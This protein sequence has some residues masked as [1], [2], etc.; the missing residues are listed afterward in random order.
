M[1]GAGEHEEVTLYRPA[2]CGRCNHTGYEGR[3]GVYELIV[4]DDKLKRLIHDGAS[5]QDIAAYAVA[6]ADTLQQS[7][8]R[9]AR[10]GLTSLEEVLRVV[11]QEEDDAG[12]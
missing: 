1:I 9:H 2:G 7:G 6:H 8:L 5:E 10:A 3:V 12:L 4:V 11:H